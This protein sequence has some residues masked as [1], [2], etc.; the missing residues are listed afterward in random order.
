M[1]MVSAI[2]VWP[3]RPMAAGGNERRDMYMYGV[4]RK[5]RA[6]AGRVVTARLAYERGAGLACRGCDRRLFRRD[7]DQT[8]FSGDPGGGVGINLQP[9]GGIERGN[10]LAVDRSRADQ[11]R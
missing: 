6:T 8:I 5:L 11:G 4:L 10:S 7:R 1:F 2:W 9:V 3:G